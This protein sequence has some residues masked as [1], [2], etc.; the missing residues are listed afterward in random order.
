MQSGVSNDSFPK[1]YKEYRALATLGHTLPSPLS[2]LS[3]WTYF[4]IAQSQV[5]K[6]FSEQGHITCYCKKTPTNPKKTPKTQTNQK[7]SQILD[8]AYWR[9]ELILSKHS[10]CLELQGRFVYFLCSNIISLWCS[11]LLCLTLLVCD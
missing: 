3:D 7:T 5:L 11:F 8:M 10:I 4:I 1:S 2:T 9:A 6:K